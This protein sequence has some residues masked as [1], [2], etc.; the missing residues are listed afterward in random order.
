MT[1]P[2]T[3]IQNLSPI[4]IPEVIAHTNSWVGDKRNALEEYYDP[5]TLNARHKYKAAHLTLEISEGEAYLEFLGLIGKKLQGC[6]FG[7]GNTGT[8]P[9]T[10]IH[11]YL[12]DQYYSMG[13]F[14]SGDWR[15]G[16][17]FDKCDYRPSIGVCSPNVYLNNMNWDSM[18]GYIKKSIR[19][20]VAIKN[21]LQYFSTK[22]YPTPNEEI[23][24]IAGEFWRTENKRSV[25]SRDDRYEVSSAAQKVLNS[26]GLFDELVAL[27]DL[28]HVFKNPEVATLIDEAVYLKKEF[29]ESLV[30]ETMVCIRVIPR[31]S[32]AT[33]QCL[34]SAPRFWQGCTWGH[35]RHTSP[36]AESSI[37]TYSEETFPDNL[38]ARLAVLNMGEVRHFL[39]GVGIKWDEHIY[40]IFP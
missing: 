20:K 39:G 25:V 32:G 21:A 30:G 6:L 33:Y 13:W 28:G 38:R 16:D 18:Q 8:T 3:H 19:P 31:E 27:H 5:Q 14:A 24:V 2:Y 11:V 26:N 9:S 10:K 23:S 1:Y 12:P 22:H 15:I 29:A 17:N 4:T 36:I 35:A 34:T 7:V 40:S 37:Q